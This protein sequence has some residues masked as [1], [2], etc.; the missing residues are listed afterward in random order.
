MRAMEAEQL[1]QRPE[2]SAEIEE[3]GAHENLTTDQEQ[4]SAATEIH[5]RNEKGYRSWLRKTMRR[6]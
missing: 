5:R 1:S 3:P 6:K 2:Q 4:L